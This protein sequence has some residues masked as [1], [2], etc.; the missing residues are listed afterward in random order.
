[1]SQ[2]QPPA[3]PAPHATPTADQPDSSLRTTLL[4]VLLCAVALVGGLGGF[5]ALASLKEPPAAR[6]QVRKI[7]NVEVFDVERSDLQEILSAFGTAR[8]DR[9]VVISAQV[10]GEIVDIHPRLKVGYEV[11]A[12]RIRIGEAGES[13]RLSGDLL[14]R[15]DPQPYQERVIQARNRLAEDA[16]ELKRLDQ[17]EANNTRLLAKVQAD[18][19]VI[20]EEFERIQELRKTNAVSSSQL[21]RAQLEVQQYQEA[22]IKQENDRDLF[23]ARRDQIRKRQ[24]T[25]RNDLEM[26]TLDLNRTEVR[27]PFSGILS[28]VLVEEGQFVR[29]G[30]PLVR[31]T[32]ISQ[33]EIPVPL[34]LRD[35]AKLKPKVDAGE[36]PPVVLAENETAGGRWFGHVVRI[37]PQADELTR[38][39]NV[40]VL[41]EN[42]RQSVPL[43]AGTFVH[44][45]IDGPVLPAAIAVPRDA[46][47][48]G[49]LF[50][51]RDGVAEA[52]PAKVQ[53]T[54]QSL[55]VL[56]GGVA[57]GEHVILTN[58]DIIHQGAQV[59]VQSHRKLVE[60]LKNQ[61]I[62]SARQS[63]AG[64][65]DVEANGRKN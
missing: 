8:A 21:A 44:A 39:I 20:Q 3:E 35:Y 60:E 10:A 37:A 36:Y 47:V 57:P 2:F 23:P 33:V 45:R 31:L 25:H 26:A 61:R 49:N 12:P 34:T 18:F 46:L 24:E 11:S 4:S 14:V 16:A 7:Y 28:E 65:A 40:F 63:L 62:P 43:L 6:E 41:V 17:E 55:A 15:I 50:V 29:A 56:E 58:L 64:G 32:D 13:E 22:I 38:T 52:R 5:L 48:N 53:Q 9:E 51:A 27:P 42:Q 59:N 1:M 19:Q 54:L 30:D